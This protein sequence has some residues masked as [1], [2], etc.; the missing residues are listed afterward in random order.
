M[1]CGMILV[2]IIMMAGVQTSLA[3]D[4][5]SECPN[6]LCDVGLS[7]M[8]RRAHKVPSLRNVSEHA[9]YKA[10]HVHKKG[11]EEH[12]MSTDA[13]VIETNKGAMLITTKVGY[14]GQYLWQGLAYSA[15]CV[16]LAFVLVCAFG[17]QSALK[18]SHKNCVEAKTLEVRRSTNFTQKVLDIICL[19]TVVLLVC[20]LYVPLFDIAWWKSWHGLLMTI[21][22]PGFMTLGRWSYYAD[23]CWGADSKEQRRAVHAT[24]MALATV[25]GFIAF[26]FVA[27]LAKHPFFAYNFTLKSW[28]T[29]PWCVGHSVLGSL[30]IVCVF[31]QA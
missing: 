20:F 15:I 22:F 21:A 5:G 1:A 6:D 19:A 17:R 12:M 7:L 24:F 4:S 2:L 9:T 27:V 31:A 3:V 28:S 11:E 29:D 8:Q 16:F 25:L 26:V 30:L 23:P 10:G 14:P 18:E 13:S